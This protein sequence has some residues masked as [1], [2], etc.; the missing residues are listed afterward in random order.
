[1][2]RR[3]RQ[4]RPDDRRQ[5]VVRTG[6]HEVWPAPMLNNQD[7]THSVPYGWSIACSSFDAG[8]IARTIAV[9]SNGMATEPISAHV[10]A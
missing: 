8:N 10:V 6:S 4:H 9:S 1:M 2:L 3:R 7:G 5:Q